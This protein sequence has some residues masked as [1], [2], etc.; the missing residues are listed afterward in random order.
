MGYLKR[1]IE[2]MKE[3]KLTLV[4]DTRLLLTYEI[5]DLEFIIFSL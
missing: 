1:K 3:K 4:S 2:K 5:L